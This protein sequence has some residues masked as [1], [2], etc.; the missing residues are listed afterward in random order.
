MR[1]HALTIAILL[2][3]ASFARAERVYVHDPAGR[4]VEIKDVDVQNDPANCGQ[5]EHAC[6]AGETCQAGQCLACN[7][8]L[9]WD[10]D[11]R[12]N[13]TDNCPLHRNWDQ[14]DTDGD[15]VG[16]PCDNCPLDK[17]KDQL[18]TD[19]TNDGGDACDAD[20]DND[21]CLDGDDDKPK[22]D[23]SI[24]AWRIAAEC[25]DAARQVWSWDGFD[26]DMD[27]LRNCMDKDDDEDGV[28]DE[29]DV[30]PINPGNSELDC[31]RPPVSCPMTT[32]ENVCQFGGCN[33]FLIQIVSVIYPP[34]IIP[35]F[36]LR[37]EVIILIPFLAMSIEKMEAAL[38]EKEEVGRTLPSSPAWAPG[39]VRIEVWSKDEEGRPKALVAKIAEYDPSRVEVREPSGESVL[40]LTPL[41]DGRAIAIQRGEIPVPEPIG[42]EGSKGPGSR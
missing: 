42:R 14:L 11:G 9:D 27:G 10:C 39:T 40:L 22:V 32:I 41:E 7:P 30:C 3:A 36:T 19:G 6:M 1:V 35:Q 28:L 26:I 16:D 20:D 24:V 23:S 13:T 4:L 21:F 18:N 8:S 38:L 12:P 25:P 31:Q 17:N 37:S 34:V 33:Q 5:P 2:T 15:D 29:E